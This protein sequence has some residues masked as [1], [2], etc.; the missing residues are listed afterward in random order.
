[1]FHPPKEKRIMVFSTDFDFYA[2][3]R[4]YIEIKSKLSTVPR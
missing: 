1:L 3:R 2:G 4:R